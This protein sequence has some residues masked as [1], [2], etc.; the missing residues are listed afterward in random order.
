MVRIRFYQRIRNLT[1]LIQLVKNPHYKP[2]K[3]RKFLEH[4]HLIRRIVCL[5]ASAFVNLR[6]NLPVHIINRGI[7]VK[8]HEGKCLR[9]VIAEFFLNDKRKG[10]KVSLIHSAAFNKAVH[11]RSESNGFN[12]CRKQ[13]MKKFV[14]FFL[15]RQCRILGCNILFDFFKFYVFLYKSFVVGSVWIQVRHNHMHCVHIANPCAVPPVSSFLLF[16]HK[17]SPLPLAFSCKKQ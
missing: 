13:N 8:L 5:I 6:R 14:F 7:F 1:T 3:T 16:F 11:F 10:K 17:Q 12:Q 15:F 2:N 4:V 9:P